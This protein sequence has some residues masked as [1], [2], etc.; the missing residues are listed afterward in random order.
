MESTVHDCTA[1]RPAFGNCGR[2]AGQGLLG[3]DEFL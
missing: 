1:E 3:A 2:P